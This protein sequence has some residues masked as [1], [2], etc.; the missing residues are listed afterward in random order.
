MSKRSSSALE[1]GKAEEVDESIEA[2]INARLVFVRMYSANLVHSTHGLDVIAQ[3]HPEA[4]AAL[5]A[6]RKNDAV[7]LAVEERDKA[8][9]YAVMER[10]DACGLPVVVTWKHACYILTVAA[11]HP[12]VLL[13]DASLRRGDSGDTF[14]VHYNAH[15][16]HVNHPHFDMFI[17][18]SIFHRLHK[19]VLEADRAALATGVPPD[20]ASVVAQF[21]MPW[22]MPL[23][24]QRM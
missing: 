6:L 15:R 2:S 1:E 24:L 17:C 22:T 4:F 20:I 23:I 8:A 10:V 18:E 9:F 13:R 21:I 5:Q 16:F 19:D 12:V 14:P 3:H 11:L 7:R